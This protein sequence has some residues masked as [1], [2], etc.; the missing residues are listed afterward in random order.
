MY[1]WHQSGTLSRRADLTSLEY[2]CSKAAVVSLVQSTAHRLLGSGVRVNGV[3]PGYVMTDLSLKVATDFEAMGAEIKGY[4]FRFPPADPAQIASVVLFLARQFKTATARLHGARSDR[5][6]PFPWGLAP[7]GSRAT[8][9]AHSPA[10][11]LACCSSDERVGGTERP[12]CV[13]LLPGSTCTLLH[14]DVAARSP[15]TSTDRSGRLTADHLHR[16]GRCAALSPSPPLPEANTTPRPM[17]RCWLSQVLTTSALLCAALAMLADN[18]CRLRF[19]KWIWTP[20]AAQETAEQP[21]THPHA[22]ATTRP[23]CTSPLLYTPA[24]L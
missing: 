1:K 21:V 6:I 17:Y 11:L 2:S 23:P 7:V 9:T 5:D 10:R 19:D 24:L 22:I 16:P 14:V 18:C 12:G 20:A 13:F 15:V 8:P 4:D 3:L